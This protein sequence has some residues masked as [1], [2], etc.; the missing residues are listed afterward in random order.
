MHTRSHT[1][2]KPPKCDTQ[3]IP[4]SLLETHMR[5]CIEE[6]PFKYGRGNHVKLA[7]TGKLHH[8]NQIEE[9]HFSCEICGKQFRTLSTMRRHRRNHAEERKYTCS[10]CKKVFDSSSRHIFERHQLDHELKARKPTGIDYICFKCGA[11]FDMASCLV[12]HINDIHQLC[13][14]IT[15]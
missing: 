9:K 10:F 4:I 2:Q 5:S 12:E 15:D 6:K 3:T 1:E 13:T 14:S 8:Q 7:L 11:S